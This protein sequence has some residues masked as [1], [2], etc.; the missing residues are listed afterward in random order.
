MKLQ[1]FGWMVLS[2]V[3]MAAVPR[4][5]AAQQR[6]PDRFPMLESRAA[7]APPAHRLASQKDEFNFI[8]FLVFG[9]A[10]AVAGAYVGYHVD[11]Y[12]GWSQGDDPG[13]GGFLLG[14][15][16]GGTAGMIF[17]GHLGND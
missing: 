2:G 13:L 7:P 10:G 5:A 4:M 1:R 12:F 6:E 8:G 3:V 16:I 15:I 17:G 14:G 9:A 11:K